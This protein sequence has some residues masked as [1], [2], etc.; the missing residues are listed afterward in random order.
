MKRPLALFTA[1]WLVL[2]CAGCSLNPS[3]LTFEKLTAKITGLR[4]ENWEPCEVTDPR[5]VEVFK[6]CLSLAKEVE[7]RG[8]K[9]DRHPHRVTLRIG[10]KWME[11][12]LEFHSYEFGVGNPS[13]VQWGGKWYEVSE[14]FRA[15]E[16][17]VREYRPESFDIDPQDEEFLSE[18]GWSPF[19]LVSETA[20]DL[21]GEL[22]HRPGEFPVVIYWALNN[23]LSK[24]IGL[25]LSAYFG[26]AV[27]VRLYKT[28]RLLPEFMGPNRDGGKAVV[29]RAGEDIVGGWLTLGRHSVSSCSLVGRSFDEV[30]GKPFDEW[31]MFLIDPDDPLEKELAAMSPEEVIETY[32]NA[33]DRKDYALAHAC[34]SRSRLFGYLGMNMDNTRLHNEGFAEEHGKGF[35]NFISIKVRDVGLAS[36]K[37]GV[38]G[39]PDLYYAAVEQYRKELAGGPDGPSGYFVTVRQE[40]PET[41]WRIDSIGTGP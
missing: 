29:V 6:G 19:F 38:R 15:M 40:T 4:F 1:L 22:I 13:Y 10:D 30:A 14:D 34:E 9:V 36:E 27:Q 23:E 2:A 18:F 41:R 26:K 16:S 25:D 11:E 31:V 33:I 5:A 21:P 37:L 24:D 28:V 8:D 32:Y 7:N 17:A 35:A 12:P 20:V 39:H 3:D